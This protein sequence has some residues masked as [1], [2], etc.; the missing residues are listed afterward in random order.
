MKTKK[1]K[2]EKKSKTAL[3]LDENI[4]GAFCY[5]FG[6][7]SGVVFLLLEKEDKFVRFHAMQSLVVFLGLF[8]ISVIPFIGFLALPFAPL[9]I[10][11]WLVLIYKAYSGE[12][13]KLPVIGN[14][15]EKQLAK[16]DK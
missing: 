11:L 7:V 14:F 12:K 6:F 10:I 1:S 4:E 15:A 16:L 8:L 3:N 13:F 9:T 2:I 5:V